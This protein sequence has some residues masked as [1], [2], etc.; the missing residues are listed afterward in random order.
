M[1]FPIPK[2]RVPLIM[3]LLFGCILIVPCVFTATLVTA[4]FACI[5]SILLAWGT[6][7]LYCKASQPTP[8]CLNDTRE[9][10]ITMAQLQ[11][12]LSNPFSEL[13]IQVRMGTEHRIVSSTTVTEEYFHV[14]VI[15]SIDPISIPLRSSGRMLGD[16]SIQWQVAQKTIFF[17]A[18]AWQGPDEVLK[19]INTYITK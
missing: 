6:T 19:F 5:G 11:T 8:A 7:G 1:Q 14:Y 3:G 16:G 15:G 10:T 17:D 13:I 2:T 12:L 18:A 4:F 9:T